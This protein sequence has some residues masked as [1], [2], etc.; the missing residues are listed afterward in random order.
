MAGH[1]GWRDGGR[2]R[3][4]AFLDF[5]PTEQ[6]LQPHADLWLTPLTGVDPKAFDGNWVEVLDQ[7]DRVLQGR[8][9]DC[10]DAGEDDPLLSLASLVG[11]AC[12]NAAESNLTQAT[13][14]LATCESIAGGIR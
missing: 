6:L 4:G 1:S 2:Q 14:P 7:A 5:R 3:C 12:Q 8:L 10:G 11:I 13:V 9:E